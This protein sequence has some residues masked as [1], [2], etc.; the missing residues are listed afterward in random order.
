MRFIRLGDELIN[1]TALARAEYRQEGDNGFPMLSL[2]YIGDPEPRSYYCEPAEVL[3][4]AIGR[5]GM[6]VEKF[7]R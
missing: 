7:A 4:R 5:M 1:L 3:W 2:W 6:R